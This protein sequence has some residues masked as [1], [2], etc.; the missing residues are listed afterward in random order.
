MLWNWYAELSE[1]VTVFKV[2]LL[3]KKFFSWKSSCLQEAPA[4]KKYMLWII[5]DSGEKKPSSVTVAVMEKY[6]EK[7]SSSR[8]SWSGKVFVTKELLLRRSSCSRQLDILKKFFV[9]EISCFKW[10]LS[11]QYNR[12]CSENTATSIRNSF[13]GDWCS[14]IP[15][16][17]VH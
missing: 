11:F 10:L 7:Y 14:E 17:K 12:C 1:K 3:L 4:S 8:S 9:Q 5:T 16:K 15:R 2:Y 13:H 6:P